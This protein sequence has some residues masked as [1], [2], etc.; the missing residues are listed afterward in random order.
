MRDAFSSHVLRTFRLLF[1]FRMFLRFALLVWLVFPQLVSLLLVLVKISV[2]CDGTGTTAAGWLGGAT[3]A[4]GSCFG[5]TTATGFTSLGT[6]RGTAWL[7]LIHITSLAV[8]DVT[9]H[10]MEIESC[11]RSGFLRLFRPC[12][13]G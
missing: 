10:L 9:V 7:G 4:A 8:Q 5:G 13:L 11:T 12:N 1:L 3:I 6:F 2:G